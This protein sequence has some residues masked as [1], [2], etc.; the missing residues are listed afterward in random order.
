MSQYDSRTRPL[1]PPNIPY[2]QPFITPP[3]QQPYIPIQQ[4]Y[5]PLPNNNIQ[6]NATSFNNQFR[7]PVPVPHFQSAPIIEPHAVQQYKQLLNDYIQ[8]LQH[9]VN[10]NL[11]TAD[12]I[13]DV[14]SRLRYYLCYHTEPDVPPTTSIQFIPRLLIY[15]TDSNRYSTLESTHTVELLYLLYSIIQHYIRLDY[16]IHTPHLLPHLHTTYKFIPTDNSKLLTYYITVYT[17]ILH[18]AMCY[19]INE[20]I[21]LNERKLVYH[22]IVEIKKSILSLLYHK[23]DTVR[24]A[25][26]VLIEHTIL[27]QSNTIVTTNNSIF[28]LNNI[29]P[30]NQLIK[31][32]DIQRDADQLLELLLNLLTDPQFNINNI[33]VLTTCCISI[34]RQRT[35]YQS[36]VVMHIIR[37]Q[38]NH[39]FRIN[40]SHSKQLQ[41]II[42]LSLLT[43]V[44]CDIDR[45]LL[46]NIADCMNKMGYN[47]DYA[48]TKKQVDH[49]KKIKQRELQSTT[50][51]T[52]QQ[53][54]QSNKQYTIDDDEYK[55]LINYA[56]IQSD[57][58]IIDIVIRS[59]SN[60]QSPPSIKQSTGPNQ[61]FLQF[62]A[63]IHNMQ[64][65][66][67]Q[68]QQINIQTTSA[69]RIVTDPRQRATVTDHASV[70]SQPVS[71][72]TKSVQDTKI[73]IAAT[74]SISKQI[75]Q[76]DSIVHQQQQAVQHTK[77]THDIQTFTK[78][79]DIIVPQ[80]THEQYESQSRSA[81]ARIASTTTQQYA[82]TAA[83]Q[84]LR[85]AILCK[86]STTNTL[87]IEHTVIIDESIQPIDINDSAYNP[88]IDSI[89]EVKSSLIQRSDYISMLNYILADFIQRYEIG[90]RWLY[91]L[92]TI[93]P[94]TV[95]F[96][97]KSKLE[98]DN[99]LV[100]TAEL[101]W[102]K[103]HGQYDELINN[104]SDSDN[105]VH[106]GEFDIP[107]SETAQVINDNTIN[108]RK[109]DS[110]DNDNGND[111]SPSK[112][113]KIGSTNTDSDMKV[114]EPILPVTDN[115]T[116]EAESAQP[117]TLTTV[118]TPSCQWSWCCRQY[119]TPE[120][121]ETL[122]SIL[123]SI[124]ATLLSDD[125]NTSQHALFTRFILDIP[126]IVDNVYNCIATLLNNPAHMHV[127]IST[128][129]SMIL[130][131]P[132]SRN[133]TLHYL[134][135]LTNE[136][137]LIDT[138]TAAINA[139]C[140][141][142]Y[143][144]FTTL[145]SIILDY[146]RQC[147]Q[148]VIDPLTLDD[149]PEIHVTI[150]QPK[151]VDEQI[152]LWDQQQVIDKSNPDQFELNELNNNNTLSTQQK[153]DRRDEIDARMR[154]RQV[155]QMMRQA[156]QR[157]KQLD[158][159]TQKY[160]LICREIDIVQRTRDER[161]RQRTQRVTT[162]IQLYYHLCEK[163]ITLLIELHDIY[164]QA[165]EFISNILIDN[166]SIIIERIHDLNVLLPP[167]QSI[168]QHDSIVQHQDKSMKWL[169]QLLQLMNDKTEYKLT[170][171]VIQYY[172]TLF[173]STQSYELFIALY[174]NMTS[175]MLEQHVLY[176][177]KLDDTQIRS[178]VQLYKTNESHVQIKKV[179]LFIFVIKMIDQLEQYN[180]QHID[181]PS[182]EPYDIKYYTEK[183]IQFVTLLLNDKSLYTID[184]IKQIINILLLDKTYCKLL[185]RFV[186]QV[187]FIYKTD[188]I[189]GGD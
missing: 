184:N 47:D 92:L 158:I 55:L 16:R 144:Q 7:P 110:G 11:S 2:Q 3:P 31:A 131:R 35:S 64:P 67:Q 106:V 123:Q 171:S 85:I 99:Q 96:I 59:M 12:T 149:I 69:K 103:E 175:D 98:Y 40:E 140:D 133:D 121:I 21:Q 101:Q 177:M 119:G 13:K 19:C 71:D 89:I 112:R 9:A 132:P 127:A 63:A 5:L 33:G 78:I 17:T 157:R 128:L 113:T 15:L 18:H 143:N 161:Q 6:Y 181:D 14:C 180:Q 30:Q 34:A 167:L 160:N 80:Y 152:E 54:I 28:T 142:V 45:V 163:H 46:D 56:G 141:K 186:I 165:D 100:H 154:Q 77:P 156:E 153:R 178:I 62:L 94:T 105:D 39:A 130:L 172:M 82:D 66:Q 134:L 148:Q 51:T 38:S 185:F 95:I 93:K 72:H 79:P 41:Y 65:V 4:Q 81:F 124:V 48:A 188:M 108:K 168:Q 24:H 111:D 10:T 189:E 49:D 159:I 126:K 57:T 25:V 68:Q 104:E 27:M 183:N 164:I 162:L 125:A 8:Q 107:D 137:D 102:L 109:R 117:A 116:S 26:V 136:H 169:V 97:N 135:Q 139:V 20:T 53:N 84:S 83:Q 88:S 166:L 120:Y 32:S 73:D 37:T 155:Q 60:F 146:A 90:I 91:T 29:Q 122:E 52:T 147:I 115:D 44:K 75:E 86:L 74:E 138:R 170:P 36:R 179:N 23:Y 118:S 145:Q 50:N 114:D 42:K 43:L 129:V 58:T 70:A 173:S 187:Y 61:S 1:P 22:N 151:S 150:Q 176:I 174:H 87:N 76:I 182:I